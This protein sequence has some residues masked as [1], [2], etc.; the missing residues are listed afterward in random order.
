MSSL[1]IVLAF[2]LSAGGSLTCMAVKFGEGIK[3]PAPVTI[4]PARPVISPAIQKPAISPSADY[5]QPNRK[6][7]KEPKPVSNSLNQDAPIIRD[8]QG[9][10]LGKLSSDK[11]DPES[12]SNPY[13]AG[14][15]YKQDGV[16]NPYGKHG[17]SYS[18]ESVTNQFATNAPEIVD[19]QGKSLGK[20]SSN[21][22]DPDSVANPYG[23]GSKYKQDGVNNPNSKNY[24]DPAL[25]KKVT[26]PREVSAS[27][28]QAGDPKPQSLMQRIFGKSKS[29]KK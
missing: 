12:V 14:S 13:G 19:T 23:A 28:E 26:K 3:P 21:S 22:Y 15:E 4:Y 5:L 24:V 7:T 2:L 17:S 16:N 11:Y 1:R 27:N 29:P 6:K 8:M 20:L 25:I 9:K 18:N 10:S